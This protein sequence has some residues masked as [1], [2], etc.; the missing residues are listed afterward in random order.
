MGIKEKILICIIAVAAIFA[1]PEIMPH[2]YKRVSWENYS[3]EGR[4]LI[5][6]GDKDKAVDYFKAQ[7]QDVLRAGGSK[8][9]RYV[10]TLEGL[11]LAYQRQD[12][13]KSA[14]DQFNEAL[15]SLSKAWVPDRMRIRQVLE[16][17]KKMYED[18][19]E[20][21]NAK[22]IALRIT[23]LNPWW[24]WFWTGFII[25]FLAESLY[26]AHV[27]SKPGDIEWWHWK[28]DYGWLYL[29]SVFVATVGMSRGLWMNGAVI[30]EAVLWSMAL[31]CL[32]LPAVLCSVLM[33]A[34][35]MGSEDARRFLT[36]TS[37]RGGGGEFQRQV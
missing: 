14:D 15:S 1:V 37:K 3:T 11:A 20:V 6:F 7:T 32:A 25:A 26:V 17:K 29:W 4:R 33:L 24:Q 31:S 22:E 16:L 5:L 18:H 36:P 27:I 35:Q 12:M 21:G 19:P 34:R 8:D 30:H 28:V 23:G 2:F 10:A 9:P 13:F